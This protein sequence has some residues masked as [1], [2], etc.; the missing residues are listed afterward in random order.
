MK[1]D[2]LLYGILAWRVKHVSNKNFLFFVSF[3]IGIVGGLA[4]VTL[5]LAVHFIHH[6]TSEWSPVAEN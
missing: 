5:K 4:A 6:A 2:R 1:L 3:L